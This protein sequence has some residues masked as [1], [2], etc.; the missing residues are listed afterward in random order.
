[1]GFNSPQSISAP[2]G[3]LRRSRERT[4]LAT[5]SLQSLPN[6]KSVPNGPQRSRTAAESNAHSE[7]LN[8]TTRRAVKEDVFIWK[9]ASYCLFAPAHRWK[10]AR[11]NTNTMALHHLDALLTCPFIQHTCPVCL[12]ILT[13][14]TVWTLFHPCNS[15]RT[16]FPAAPITSCTPALRSWRLGRQ[17]FQSGVRGPPTGQWAASR[18]T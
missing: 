16:D 13:L 12:T 6:G 9:Y 15:N 11:C 17:G 8:E 2:P 5:P 1:M 14:Q 18:W 10:Y 7:E 3:R 4:A